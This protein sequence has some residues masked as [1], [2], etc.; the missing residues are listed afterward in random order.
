[1]TINLKTGPV[2]ISF[3]FNLLYALLCLGKAHP[4]QC[5]MVNI[6]IYIFKKLKYIFKYIYI[7]VYIV[8][9]FYMFFF[10]CLF[11]WSSVFTFPPLLCPLVSHFTVNLFI[12][13]SSFNLLSLPFYEVQ[14]LPWYRWLPVS[15]LPWLHF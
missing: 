7:K 9:S 5:H 1:M 11:S 6:Y 10:K 3:L 4:L 2:F 14:S 12:R 15:Y 13:S 8:L